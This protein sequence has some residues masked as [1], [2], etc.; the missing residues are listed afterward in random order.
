MVPEGTKRAACLPRRW[1]MFASSALTV[2]S[3]PM[4]SSPTSA[5]AMAWRISGVGFVTVSL[6]RSIMG[7]SSQFPPVHAITNSWRHSYL[8]R[9]VAFGGCFGLDIWGLDGIYRHK[10]C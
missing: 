3:S 5:L 2:G 7:F 6:R 1:A 8:G 9:F 10:N 4:T